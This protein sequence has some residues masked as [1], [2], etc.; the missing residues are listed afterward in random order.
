[1]PKKVT[2]TVCTQVRKCVEEQVPANN[3]CGGSGSNGGNASGKG[4]LFGH[5]LGCKKGC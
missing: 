5:G 4:G 3:G 1:V 2:K